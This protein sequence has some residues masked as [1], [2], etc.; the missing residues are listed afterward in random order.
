MSKRSKRRA[1]T[2]RLQKE[3]AH[4]S[5]IELFVAVAERLREEGAI[6]SAEANEFVSF[7]TLASTPE[8]YAQTAAVVATRAIARAPVSSF[9]LVACNIVGF[10]IVGPLTDAKVDSNRRNEALLLG[11]RMM[12][13]YRDYL[14]EMGHAPPQ[15]NE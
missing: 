15:A 10:T 3:I 13:E 6:D 1:E 7:L 4:M 14:R 8:Q 2:V 9:E 12:V 11:L 5:H